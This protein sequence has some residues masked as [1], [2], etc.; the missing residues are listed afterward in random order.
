[1][2]CLPGEV[3]FGFRALLCAAAAAVASGCPALACSLEC[4]LRPLGEPKEISVSYTVRR[5]RGP[6]SSCATFFITVQWEHSLAASDG[7]SWTRAADRRSGRRRHLMH[8]CLLKIA[9][10]VMAALAMR[11]D[12]WPKAAAAT[13]V[14]PVRTP[15][16]RPC[17]A[18]LSLSRWRSDRFNALCVC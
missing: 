13:D 1:M 16:A 10:S 12:G 7:E 11:V 17:L 5:R 18:T 9:L 14:T 15:G 3:I 8:A 6:L 2:L 4:D